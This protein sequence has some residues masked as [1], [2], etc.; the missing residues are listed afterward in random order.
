MMKTLEYLR[1]INPDEARRLRERGIMHTNQLLHATNLIGDRQV[2]ARR[3]GI[4][5]ERLLEFGHQCQLLEISGLDRYLPITRRLGVDSLKTLKKMEAPA[6]WRQV[7]DAAGVTAAPSLSMV[8]YWIGQ[9]RAIDVTEEDEE[10]AAVPSR[11]V[12]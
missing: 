11:V 1:G 8:E 12:G 9:A 3:T 6:L 7:I 2:L 5:A 4:P 10:G